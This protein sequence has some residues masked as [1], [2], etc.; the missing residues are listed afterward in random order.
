MML[1][2]DA[3]AGRERQRKHSQAAGIILQASLALNAIDRATDFPL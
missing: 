1:D 2:A 3:E